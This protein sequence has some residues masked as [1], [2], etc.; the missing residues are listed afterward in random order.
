MSSN[1]EWIRGYKQ[2][3]DALLA[4]DVSLYAEKK[5][6]FK[7]PHFQIQSLISL[8]EQT[9]RI[10]QSEPT[11]LHLDSSESPIVLVGDLHGHFLDLLRIFQKHGSPAQ[12]RYLFLGD[13]VDRG[14][15]SL[16]TITLLFV[17]KILYPTN[18]YMI[19]GNH[20]FLDVFEGFGFGQEIA[21]SYFDYNP[22]LLMNAFANSFAQFP[23]ACIIDRKYFCVHGGIGSNISTIYQLSNIRRPIN[24]IESN[25]AIGELLW[26]DPS[27]TIP[28]FMPSNRG[29]GYLYGLKAI[30]T[31]LKTNKLEVIIRAHQCVQNG[32][33]SNS[34]N[35]VITVFSASNY[36]GTTANNSGVLII[37]NGQH[38]EV[39]YPPLLYLRRNNAIFLENESDTQFL[40]NPSLNRKPPP[41]P[42]VHH[43]TV[44]AA[45]SAGTSPQ[46]NS[47]PPR[48]LP[49]LNIRNPQQQANHKRRSSLSTAKTSSSA[50]SAATMN[51]LAKTYTQTA[52]AL[53][54]FKQFEFPTKSLRN[55]V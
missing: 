10:F 16:E 53:G 35:T 6:K 50:L 29:T 8:N 45:Y 2:Y 34:N 17:M 33:M 51:P 23:I 27:E 40:I 15:F 13:L 54:S 43:S 24:T 37:S 3:V 21:T 36:C 31:F 46:G 5:L 12:Q 4:N 22:K 42:L 19:R 44:P 18:L 55:F 20:E 14:E 52:R 9:F 1:L 25:E 38:S 49:A 7:I 26:S 28:F 41:A 47:P 30:E 39:I 11:V 48:K 32:I